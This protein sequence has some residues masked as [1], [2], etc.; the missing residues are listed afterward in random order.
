MHMVGYIVK[1]DVQSVFVCY[2]QHLMQFLFG[3]EAFFY[4]GS[5]DWPIAVV[6]REFGVFLGVIVFVAVRKWVISPR[7]PRVLGDRRNPNRAYSEFVEEAVFDF[8]CDTCDVAALIV[9]DVEYFGAVH[10][11]VV[12]F[13]AIVEA[14]NHE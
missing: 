7:I 3:C 5:V 1:N 4:F 8:L 13:V 6:A 2:C 11:P 14:V 9:H 10:F 12:G